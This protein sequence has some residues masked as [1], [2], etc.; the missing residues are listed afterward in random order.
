M[1]QGLTPQIV[2]GESTRM[3]MCGPLSGVGVEGQAYLLGP[4]YLISK[5]GEVLKG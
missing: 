1:K 3:G 5:G 4:F 2:V